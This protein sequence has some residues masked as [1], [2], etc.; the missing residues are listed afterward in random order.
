M[1]IVF[2]GTAELSCACLEKLAGDRRF[3]VVAVVTQPDKPGGRGLKPH[4]S[5]VK[6]LAQKLALPILTPPKA[7]DTDFIAALRSLEPDLI[8]V[9][10]YGHILPPAIL[11]L[12]KWGC[13]NV[14]ASLLPRY[15][16]AAPIQWAIANGEHETGVTIMKMDAG[17]D[18]GDMLATA[19]TPILPDDDS[20]TLHE[21][22]GRL[23]A[24][25]LVTTIPG[26]VEGGI[27]PRPQP[28]G[29]TFAPK[30]RKEDGDI[31]W[32]LPAA[33]IVNRIRAFT[34]WPGAWTSLKT[35]AGLRR[36]RMWKAQA[37][38]RRMETGN[39][40]PAPGEI[41]KADKEGIDLVCG[42]G[43]L[44]ILELQ[45]ESGRR[46]SAAAFLTGH[47]LKAGEKK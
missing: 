27:V 25:L 5:P 26:Y 9:A 43:T 17:L 16:G 4:P 38:D 29:A 37:R 1:K 32:H 21:R 12:P 46:M 30:V 34:P 36:V 20:Q 2:M 39:A 13:L 3:P 19:A 10:A 33:G 11:N 23:G 24:E 28:S 41:L 6:I 47:A 40:W 45:P 44:R 31:D 7:R 15:R 8:V 22:L 42:E 18:T 35:A 14:H